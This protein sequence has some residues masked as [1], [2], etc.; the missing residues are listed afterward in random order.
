M[1]GKLVLIATPIGNYGDLS[2]RALEALRTADS[3]ACEDSR[4]TGSL[5]AHFGISHSPFLVC[6]EHTEAASAEEIVSRAERGEVVA[7]VSDAGT[8]AIS[9]PGYRVVREA[10]ERG[11]EIESIPGA[12]AALAGLVVSGIATDRFCF[13]GFLPRKGVQRRQRISELVGEPRTSILF[14]A[15]H[16]IEK[17]VK[18]LCAALDPER[19]VALARELTKTFEEV[20]R[21]SLADAALF[22]RDREPRGEYVIV[23]EGAKRSEASADDLIEALQR[24]LERGST[25]RDAVD[26][27]VG[28]TG[29]K[30][31]QVYDLALRLDFGSPDG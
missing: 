11:V 18:D 30:K 2:P 29:A 27:V 7:L 14:E 3:V 4:R 6:N 31:R 23:I 20:W 26:A 22:L 17:T 12:S 21:G 15:P 10:I 25:R 1:T 24:E 8:P 28:L 9:D 19:E 13:E 5:F 16:R